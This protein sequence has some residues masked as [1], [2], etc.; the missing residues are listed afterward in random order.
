MQMYLL[1]FQFVSTRFS[2]IMGRLLRGVEVFDE[3]PNPIPGLR[4][5][6]WFKDKW[7]NVAKKPN[8]K[9]NSLVQLFHYSDVFRLH[10][11]PPIKC[12]SSS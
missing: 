6:A 4:L 9:V 5:P 8:T 10:S 2:P 7:L 3:D 11:A 12:F 1:L